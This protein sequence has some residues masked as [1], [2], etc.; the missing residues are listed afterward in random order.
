MPQR[1]EFEGAIHEFP[2]DFTDADIAAALGEPSSPPSAR[3]GGATTTALGMTAAAPVIERLGLELATSPHVTKAV[4]AATGPAARMASRA[5]GVSTGSIPGYLASEAVA[6]AAKS[7]AARTA[8]ETAIRGGGQ[9]TAAVGRV[10]GRAALPLQVAA[11][12]YDLYQ[13]TTPE[14]RAA[15]AAGRER[16]AAA[17][18]ASGRKDARDMD[19]SRRRKLTTT[20]IARNVIAAMGG[21]K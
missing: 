21:K 9:A 13:L 1:I 7:P 17:D 11:T 14:S 12:A 3:G 16:V 4:K 10:L 19:R 8:A 20:E 5:I 15:M 18:A 2:D 6:S